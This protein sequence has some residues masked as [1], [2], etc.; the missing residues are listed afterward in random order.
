MYFTGFQYDLFDVS[1]RDFGGI[2]MCILLFMEDNVGK[3]DGTA[4]ADKS[5]DGRTTN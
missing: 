1:G 2:N 3:S 4:A 5:E